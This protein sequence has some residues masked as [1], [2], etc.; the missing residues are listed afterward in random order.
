M[1]AA[2]WAWLPVCACASARALANSEVQGEVQILVS[3]RGSN[4]TVSTLL[5]D[6]GYCSYAPRN[7]P[8]WW[9]STLYSDHT[10]MLCSKPGVHS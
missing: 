7:S 8:Q 2:M 3:C 1:D 5:V 6:E 9:D 4:K 10:R